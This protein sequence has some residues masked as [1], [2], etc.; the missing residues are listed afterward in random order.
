MYEGEEAIKY[1]ETKD[2]TAKTIIIANGITVHKNSI[3]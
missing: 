3:R 2:G 1:R